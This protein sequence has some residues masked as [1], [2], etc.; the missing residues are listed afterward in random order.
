MLTTS[1]TVEYLTYKII[2]DYQ[3]GGSLVQTLDNFDF[4]VIP[5]VNPDGKP[6]ATAI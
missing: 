1:Q 5:V 4:F 2:E 3:A 6:S